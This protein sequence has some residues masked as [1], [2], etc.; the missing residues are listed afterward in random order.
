MATSTASRILS[1]EFLDRS[2]ERATRAAKA[3]QRA[4]PGQLQ[5]GWVV[6]HTVVI[7]AGCLAWSR[8]VHGNLKDNPRRIR[9]PPPLGPPHASG[10]VPCPRARHPA[11]GRLWHQTHQHFRAVGRVA[12][13]MPASP[14]GLC[15]ATGLGRKGYPAHGRS[16]QGPITQ[17]AGGWE[18]GFVV[19][20]R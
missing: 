6:R 2:R 3:S 11:V 16:R 7:E 5:R 18:V 8:P 13:R 19:G 17:P 20:A 15:V 12:F 9:T 14:P 4:G 10:I 1:E